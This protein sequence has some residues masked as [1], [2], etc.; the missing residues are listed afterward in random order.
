MFAV[1]GA[2]MRA[3]VGIFKVRIKQP[4]HTITLHLPVEFHPNRTVRDR[5]MMSYPF[6]K[7][8]PRHPNS[9]SGFSFPDFAHLGRPKST[10]VPNFSEISQS[11]TKIL[12]FP[13]SEKRP[14][15]GI[16]LPVPV[17]MFAS[18]SA[19][20]GFKTCLSKTKTKTQQFQDQDQDQDLLIQDQDQDQ[21]FDVQDQDRDSRLTMT[22]RPTGSP[23][24]GWTVTNKK[25]W[26]AENPAYQ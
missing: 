11:T 22:N 5:V 19:R 15:C 17:F 9:T 2:R 26:Q 1:L 18:P 4:Q 3:S 23:W 6:F 25:S 16:L 21:D 7:M 24:L 10:C 20:L 8:A 13:V 14:P 12:L